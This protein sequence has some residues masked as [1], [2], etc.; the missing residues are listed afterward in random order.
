M[1]N[2]QLF[3]KNCFNQSYG[4]T[5]RGC[6]GNIG[7]NDLWVEALEHN[8]HPQCFV[9]TVSVGGAK[10]HVSTVGGEGI[11]MGGAGIHVFTVGG[12]GI[13]VFTVGGAE[14]H[15]FTVG[16]TGVQVFTVGGAETRPT[17]TLAA[18]SNNI[19][20]ARN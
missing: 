4:T 12:A 3:C 7:A 8:W 6:Q 5:C 15:V 18:A 10:G 19:L 16:G 14:V 13:H 17:N 11:T 2:N 9:C 1:E 20:C